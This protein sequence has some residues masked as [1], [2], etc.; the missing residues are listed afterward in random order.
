M[1]R[2]LVAFGNVAELRPSGKT[3]LAIEIDNAIRIPIELQVMTNDARSYAI[4]IGTIWID[5]PHIG[6]N[7][8][9]EKLTVAYKEDD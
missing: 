2:V 6:F 4:F 9:K 3:E 5:Q 7:R 1:T 8:E